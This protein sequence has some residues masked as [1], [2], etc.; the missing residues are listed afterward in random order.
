MRAFI[1]NNGY[2]NIQ[3]ETPAEKFALKWHSKEFEGRAEGGGIVF[4]EEYEIPLAL[5]IAEISQYGSLR[6]P[7][8]NP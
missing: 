8:H 2:I 6:G 1:D 3:A 7:Q 5:D 4:H